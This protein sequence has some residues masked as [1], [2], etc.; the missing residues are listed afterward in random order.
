LPLN[1]LSK[2]IVLTPYFQHLLLL[3]E[4][5]RMYFEYSPWIFYHGGI[6]AVDG[7]LLVQARVLADVLQVDDRLGCERWPRVGP[8]EGAIG[9][10]LTS[11]YRAAALADERWIHWMKIKRNEAWGL[12]R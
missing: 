3:L 6:V 5:L 9:S 10:D 1:F 2:R 8:L 7:I 11:K 12:R 4:K